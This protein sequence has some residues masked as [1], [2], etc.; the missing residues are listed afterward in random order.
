MHEIILEMIVFN[1]HLGPYNIFINV[2]PDLV[3]SW[4]IKLYLYLK[5]VLTK[6]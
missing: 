3:I 6:D 5:N 1:M 4:T 2:Y